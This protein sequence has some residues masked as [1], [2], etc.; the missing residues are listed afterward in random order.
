MAP[1]LEDPK[2]ED[3]QRVRCSVKGELAGRRVDYG[4]DAHHVPLAMGLS[5]AVLLGIGL[6]S[7]IGAMDAGGGAASAGPAGTGAPGWRPASSPPASPS[8]RHAAPPE[9]DA[10]VAAGA[11]SAA[12]PASLDASSLA[13][14]SRA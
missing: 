1:S 3:P 13:R 6:L 8:D 14:A 10:R 7:G 11:C 12:L 2:A 9:S 4:F 5:G